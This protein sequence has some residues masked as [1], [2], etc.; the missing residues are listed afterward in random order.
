M[1]DLKPY[2][3]AVNA[4]EEGVQRVANEINALFTQGTD[5]STKQALA[6]RPAL[7]EAQA[8]HA[9]AVGLYEAM[10]K[11]NRPNDAARN[12]VPVSTTQPDQVADGSQ[13][14]VI[15]RQDYERLTLNERAQFIRLG[16]KL[17]D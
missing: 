9:E 14:S 8:K 3:D 5:E 7:D 17:E 10:Q 4:A 16:G 11:A 2:F 6:L 1:L 12:F 15:K 13:P